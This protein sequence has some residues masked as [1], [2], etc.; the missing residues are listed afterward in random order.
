MFCFDS[1]VVSKSLRS[2]QEA[3]PPPSKKKGGMRSSEKSLR[4]GDDARWF[5]F[6]KDTSSA[7]Q[8]EKLKKKLYRIAVCLRKFHLIT[9]AGFWCPRRTNVLCKAGFTRWKTHRQTRC[10]HVET[11]ERM[12][13]HFKQGDDGMDQWLPSQKHVQHCLG[14][15]ESIGFW[16]AI[17]CNFFWRSNILKC[18]G[19]DT[20]LYNLTNVTC[21]P[22]SPVAH[23]V[24]FCWSFD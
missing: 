17:S 13:P 8:Y 18:L 11:V 3:L 2:V 22:V 20:S 21:P 5:A 16:A 19:I 24:W 7:L 12:F 1:Y 23:R 9:W 4:I 10:S 6:S 15:E 14:P